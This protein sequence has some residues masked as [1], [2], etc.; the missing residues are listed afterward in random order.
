MRLEG[1]H[2]VS[3]TTADAPRNLDFYTRLLGLR[4]VART[5]N[6]DD[7]SHHHLFYADEVGSP[8]AELT[9]FE[10]R[11]ARDGRAG[12][13]MVHTIVSRV[14]S[15]EALAFW[16][17]RLGA[18]GVGSERTPSGALPFRDP[19]G[20]AHEL[21]VDRSDPPL[22]ARHPE[23]P[24]E[25]AIGGLVGVRAYVRAP[26]RSG[27]L[28]QHVL[29]ATPLPDGA[30]FELRGERRGG[31]IGF[32]PPPEERGI[33]GAGTVHHVAWGTTA[34][35]HPSWAARLEEAGV[36][37]TGVIDRYWFHS[38]YFREPGGVLYE[39]AD[40]RPGFLRDMS[41]EELGSRLVLPDRL[42]PRRDAIEAAL[43]PLPVPAGRV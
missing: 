7:P 2:H 21:V 5:V 20:L 15:P 13:G 9:F 8:G 3:A 26:G 35:E 18:D 17:E 31:T 42:E 40:D 22:V 33:R 25:L 28:L 4:L 24:A 27:E 23:V 37:S 12:A 16:E 43:T 30:G 29:G 11:G 38:L 39:I 34:A 14:N 10:Y 32:D 41:V 6:Q 1:I 19:E 36:R